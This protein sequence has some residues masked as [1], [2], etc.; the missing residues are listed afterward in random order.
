MKLALYGGTFD[1]IHHGHLILAREAREQLG[2]DRVVFVPA[3]LSP[4]KLA[5]NPSP[6]GV[7]VEMLRAAIAEEP[8]FE[9]DEREAARPGPS[10][11]IE[12]IEAWR[13]CEPAAEIFYLIGHDNVAEL[14]TWRRYDDLL[15]LAQFVVFGRA[16]GGAAHPFPVIERRVD[17]S[18]THLRR[19]VARGLSVRYLVPESVRA[20]VAARGLY[21]GDPSSKPKN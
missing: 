18:A 11:A 10:Y 16:D 12:T 14:P 17:I 4:H 9:L 19:R 2:L 20:I 5:S 21:Q 8:G 7:R 15:R 1:P 3:A 13:A 6:A